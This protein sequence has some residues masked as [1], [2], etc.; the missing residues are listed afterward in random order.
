MPYADPPV[1]LELEEFS[2]EEL[3]TE[4]QRLGATPHTFS[5]PHI[6]SAGRL[7]PED[8][9]TCAIYAIHMVDP[10]N[11]EAFILGCIDF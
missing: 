9:V 7:R 3:E 5:V 8:Q 2:K 11:G 1:G 6:F 4:I 10:C